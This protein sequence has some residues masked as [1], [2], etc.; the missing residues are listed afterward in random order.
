MIPLKIFKVILLGQ[1]HSLRDRE[2]EQ[3]LRVRLNFLQFTGFI[4]ESDLLDEMILCYSGN[5]LIK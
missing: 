5:K 1:W 3:S 2:L 4:L